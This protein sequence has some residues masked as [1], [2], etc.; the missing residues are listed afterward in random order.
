[1]LLQLGNIDNSVPGFY[2]RNQSTPNKNIF[3]A[4]PATFKRLQTYNAKRLHC[5]Q[6]FLSFKIK[7]A[8]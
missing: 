1:M 6:S 3:R 8:C 4:K 7:N 2:E 5:C